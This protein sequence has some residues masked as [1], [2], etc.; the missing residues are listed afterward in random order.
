MLR[1]RVYLDN[2]AYNRPFD[3][4]SQIRIFLESQ[5]KLHIQHL[6]VNKELTLAYSYMSI[7]ENNDNPHWERC[8]SIENFFNHASDYVDSGKAEIIEPNASSIMK[9]NIKNK[10]AIHIA[11]A[12]EAGCDY[13]ITTDDNLIKKYTGNDIIICGPVDF[14]K[15]LEEK[16]G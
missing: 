15:I 9:N 8:F 4:Q 3:D 13:F 5:A 16:D 1:I 12:I 2:C 7:Y 10:D 11:C 6:I 14:I